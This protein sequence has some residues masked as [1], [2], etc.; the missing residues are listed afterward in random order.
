MQNLNE[1]CI[2]KKKEEE[3]RVPSLKFFAARVVYYINLNT[4]YN[5]LKESIYGWNCQCHRFSGCQRRIGV[6]D[7]CDLCSL[8]IKH[9]PFDNE[10]DFKIKNIINKNNEL[11]NDFKEYYNIEI[12][13]SD[14]RTKTWQHFFYEYSFY[15][16]V[17]NDSIFIKKKK[18]Y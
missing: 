8:N 10:R 14:Y 16:S 13:G 4:M 1:Q 6:I 12:D 18:I 17:F 9:N 2:I 15:D 5:L 3:E 7:Y 11:V